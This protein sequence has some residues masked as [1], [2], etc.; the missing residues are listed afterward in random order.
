[1][2]QYFYICAF[3]HQTCIKCCCVVLGAVLA[4]GMPGKE[5]HEISALLELI[6]WWRKTSSYASAVE[7]GNQDAAHVVREDKPGLEEAAVS[8]N[9]VDESHRSWREQRLREL[10]SRVVRARAA[11]VHV[12]AKSPR[13][14]PAICD[15]MDSSPPGSSVH[16]IL[17]QE[18]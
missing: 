16:G 5:K 11:T 18:Y 3:V 14:C 2:G 12:R 7:G 8:G 4:L 17:Q 6:V 9:R 10:N 1:M 13:S 15:A